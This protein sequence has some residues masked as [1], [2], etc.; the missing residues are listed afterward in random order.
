MLTINVIEEDSIEDI[1]LLREYKVQIKAGAR[2]WLSQG[3]GFRRWDQ[4]QESPR[5]S[6]P[7]LCII[8]VFVDFHPFAAMSAQKPSNGTLADHTAGPY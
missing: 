7:G 6:C 1:D 5:G 3:L 8:G 2:F 4:S